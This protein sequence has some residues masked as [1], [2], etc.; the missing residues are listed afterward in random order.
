MLYLRQGNKKDL[1]KLKK[2]GK[3]EE[4]I[5]LKQQS[6]HDQIKKENVND[7]G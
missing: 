3:E 1:K 7:L 2:K 5:L 4:A 6:E